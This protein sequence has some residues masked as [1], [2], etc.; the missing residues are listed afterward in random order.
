MCSPDTLASWS[1]GSAAEVLR[2]ETLAETLFAAGLAG[3]EFVRAFRDRLAAAAPAVVA[4]KTIAAYRCGFD[5][6]WSRPSDASVARA[7]AA[8]VDRVTD[9]RLVAFGV[10]AA[11]DAGLPIQVHVGLGD[12]DGTCAGPTHCCC[13]LAAP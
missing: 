4:A 8:P 12:R 11:A 9:P 6:D 10:H 2:L 13:S 5:I 7:A 3:A 1:G